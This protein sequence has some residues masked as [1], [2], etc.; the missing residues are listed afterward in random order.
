MRCLDL[1]LGSLHIK[2]QR[3]EVILPEIVTESDFQDNGWIGAGDIIYE[4]TDKFPF[5]TTFWSKNMPNQNYIGEFEI[6]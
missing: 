3:F 1:G 4:W 6:L 5:A 2:P